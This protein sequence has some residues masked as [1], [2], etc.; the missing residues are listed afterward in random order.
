MQKNKIQQNIWS[1]FVKNRC[2]AGTIGGIAVKVQVA[3]R[4]D[5]YT[6]YLR[7]EEGVEVVS[8]LHQ[9][10]TPSDLSSSRRYALGF[11]LIKAVHPRI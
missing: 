5:W 6:E 10:G 4:S 8:T 1:R 3:P 7:K 11:E 2:D 9:G